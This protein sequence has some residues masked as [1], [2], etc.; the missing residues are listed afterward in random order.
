MVQ[1]MVYT[2]IWAPFI[3]IAHCDG[4][5]DCVIGCCGG[6]W[7]TL[8]MVVMWQPTSWFVVHHG[9]SGVPF[10]CRGDIKSKTW[11]FFPW[12]TGMVDFSII[13]FESNKKVVKKI[14]KKRT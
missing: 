10:G 5:A 3:R 1:T 7:D 14:G 4:P 13:I 9:G 8:E 2:V 11:A 12:F 6:Y